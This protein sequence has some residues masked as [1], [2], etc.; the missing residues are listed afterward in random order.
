MPPIP[1]APVSTMSTADLAAEYG[2]RDLVGYGENTPDPQWPNGAKIAI[3]LVLNYEEGSEVTP[4]NGDDVTE[5][6]A[7]EL[8]PGI[9]PMRGE[10][11]VNIE[12]LYEVRVRGLS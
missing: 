4:V 3:N 1:T 10:R 9:T 7:S 12:S 8:G 11:D 2:A 6:I 5:T